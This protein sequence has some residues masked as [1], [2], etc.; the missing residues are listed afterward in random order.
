[1]RNS[2][3]LASDTGV[4]YPTP[5][6]YPVSSGDAFLKAL[7][8]LSSLGSEAF[9]LSRLGSPVHGWLQIFYTC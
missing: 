1:M 8:R 7:S 3:C 9:G 2:G 5:S 6:L 4:S